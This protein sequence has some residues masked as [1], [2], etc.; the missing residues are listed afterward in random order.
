MQ[1]HEFENEIEIMVKVKFTYDPGEQ[2]TH[3]DPGYGP[4]YDIDLEAVEFDKQ[5]KDIRDSIMEQC[6]EAVDK[7]RIDCLDRVSE[8]KYDAHIDAMLDRENYR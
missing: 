1:D 2:Q 5:P 3:E 8:C 4:Q 7:R 6:V